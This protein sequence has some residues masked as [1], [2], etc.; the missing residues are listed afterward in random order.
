MEDEGFKKKKGCLGVALFSSA[1]CSLDA[2]NASVS[3]RERVA[4]RASC[5]AEFIRGETR[6]RSYGQYT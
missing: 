3:F 4:G 2:T 5:E 1:M 6:T